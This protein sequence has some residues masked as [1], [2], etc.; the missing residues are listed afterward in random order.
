M[1]TEHSCGAV[2]FTRQ[3]NGIIKYVI[4]ESLEG[5][6]GFPKGHAE[7][8]ETEVETALREIME[9]TGLSVNII[10]GFRT[11]DAHAYS[12][13]SETRMKHIVYFLA[14]FS[15]QTPCLQESE[16]RSVR[17]MD[18]ESAMSV[19]QF[20]STKRILSEAHDFLMNERRHR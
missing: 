13:M 17:L 14:E 9:E 3:D 7:G 10:D 2:V 4:V 6:F 18:Y 8:R 12:K 20:D 11:E 16:L 19:F 1:I 15:N 5:F